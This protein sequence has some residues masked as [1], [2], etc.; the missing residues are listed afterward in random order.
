MVKHTSEMN[1]V[2]VVLGIALMMIGAGLAKKQL[3]W[4]PLARRVRRGLPLRRR[5]AWRRQMA[6]TLRIGR[7]RVRRTP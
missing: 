7:S 2:A 1:A 4:R 6:N 3:D 5:G